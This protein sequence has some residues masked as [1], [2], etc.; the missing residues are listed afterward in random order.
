MIAGSGLNVEFALISPSGQKLAFDFRKSEAIHMVDPTEAG[1]YRLCFDNSFSK[2]S[3]KMVYFQVA[4]NAQG[5]AREEWA[6][7]AA[8]DSLVE[9][10]LNIIRTITETAHG[11]L[12]RTRQVQAALKAFEARDR[13]LLE[14]NLW[15][16]SFWS[17]LTLLVMLTV[18][19]VQIYTLR[20]LFDDKKRVCT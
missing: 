7:V 12:E 3:K 14:D 9:D 6:D 18:A 11:H 16:V 15:R 19:V 10:Q 8:K 2:M 1:D 20:R 13:Y 5:R 4:I 17:C